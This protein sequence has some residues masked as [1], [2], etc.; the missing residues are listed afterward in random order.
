MSDPDKNFKRLIAIVAEGQSLDETQAA[1]AFNIV[2]SGEA[3]PSQIAGFLM[4]LRV[5]GETVNE[6]TG[7]ARTM[8]EKMLPVR[9]PADAMDVVGTG[10]D[11]I[12]TQNIS[13]ATAL[14]VAGCGIPVAK[15]GNRAA[16]S[17]SG[18]ADVLSELGINLEA[19]IATVERAIREAGIGFLLAPVYHSAMRYVGPARVE[20]GVR[21]I[22]NILGPLANPASVKRL[23]VGTFDR[24]WVEPMAQVLGNLGV[25]RA[26]VVHGADGLD[27]LTTTGSSYVAE[28]A[29]GKVTMKEVSPKDAGLPLATLDDLKGGTPAENAA[30][31]RD[32]LGGKK[33]A[34]RDIALF[35]AAAALYIAGKTP[36]LGDGV[37]VAA[38]AIDDGKAAAALEKLSAI[39]S[40]S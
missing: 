8:R 23:L 24:R 3:T 38:A 4:A 22:F 26:W 9:A 27:E 30:S 25:E 21:T 10:G 40:G 29:D 12:G 20:M 34:F 16:S 6:I 37:S 35:G 19:D 7:A 5:R 1:E 33:G 39:T 32:L 28:L 2:M 17:K 11:G 13:T 18:A 15:H 14:V 36:E 31:I